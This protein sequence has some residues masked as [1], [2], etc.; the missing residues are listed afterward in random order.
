M[1]EF[2]GVCWPNVSYR[3]AMVNANEERRT[4]LLYNS[5]RCGDQNSILPFTDLHALFPLCSMCPWYMS[6]L[7]FF[8]PFP[9]KALTPFSEIALTSLLHLLKKEVSEHSRHLQQYFQAF[10]NYANKGPFEVCQHTYLFI[11]SCL[12]YVASFWTVVHV[13]HARVIAKV[14]LV[15]RPS[16]CPVLSACSTQKQRGK[17]WYI[18]S[19][20]WHQCLPR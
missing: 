12:L 11:V 20:E 13:S 9:E 5:V 15:P 6:H 17:A 8:L 1:T 18:L 7:S 4:S 3:M 16:H 10:L 2:L 19:R 14:S